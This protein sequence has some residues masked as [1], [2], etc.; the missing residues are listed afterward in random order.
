VSVSNYKQ[1]CELN[2]LG[3]SYIVQRC[4]KCMF[5][6]GFGFLKKAAAE[7]ADSLEVSLD[8]LRHALE[9]VGLMVHQ[10]DATSTGSIV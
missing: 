1:Q 8:K 9:H 3:C 4:V 10:D 6:V 5:G 2:S 7:Q